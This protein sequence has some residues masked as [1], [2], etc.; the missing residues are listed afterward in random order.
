ML[1]YKKQIQSVELDE[2]EMILINKLLS[3]R[4]LFSKIQKRIQNEIISL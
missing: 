1:S 4:N 2:F 3:E